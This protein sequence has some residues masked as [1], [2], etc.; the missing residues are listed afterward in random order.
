[1][2]GTEQKRRSFLYSLAG[3]G[4]SPVLV[5]GILEAQTAAQQGYVLSAGEGEHLV[6]FRDRGNIFIKIGSATGSDNLAMGTQQVMAG[7]GIP[8]HR[9]FQMDEA[10]YILE[11]SGTFTL[12]DVP[13]PFGKGATIFIPKNSWH[14]FA[15]PDHELLLLW[16][17]TPA[18]LDGF[19]REVCNP[20]GVPP[21]KLTREQV[22][23]IARKYATEFR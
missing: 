9:H 21:K 17:V 19:F 7:S 1:M 12:N 10:F 23:D 2:T 15:N 20:P 16:M 11:G 5:Q 14:G 18:G 4:I 3:L 22:N 6:H 8:V 13:H